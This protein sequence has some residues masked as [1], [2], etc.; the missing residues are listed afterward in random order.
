MRRAL[1]VGLLVVPSLFVGPDASADPP[2]N[3]A[4]LAMGYAAKEACSCA[5]LEGRSDSFCTTYG[6]QPTGLSVT[7][8]I[9]HTANTVT[10]SL[11]G[12]SRVATYTAGTG[13]VLAGL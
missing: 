10:A 11:L 8:A 5:L 3:T 7:L 9:D 4:Q 12:A 6:V 2:A 13:C 1:L